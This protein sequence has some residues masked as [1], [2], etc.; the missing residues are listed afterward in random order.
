VLFAQRW[1][2]LDVISKGRAWLAVC[3]GGPDE[4]SPA[5][6]FEHAV[7]GIKANERVR[8]ME[9]GILILRKPFSEENAVHK[10]EFYQFDTVTLQARPVQEP[11]PTWIASN[12]TG[13]TWKDGASAAK[14][15]IERSLR[16]VAHFATDG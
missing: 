6:A 1:A 16:R 9:E 5:Q 13:L 3:V 12:P 15:I 4:Q 14:P 2:S 7:M 8:R 11:V 10:G